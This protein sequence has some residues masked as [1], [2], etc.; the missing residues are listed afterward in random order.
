MCG[1]TLLTSLFFLIC[2]NFYAD[3]LLW[4]GP[5]FYCKLLL[6]FQ[7]DALSKS[8]PYNPL[9]AQL[10]E[11]YGALG[12]PLKIAKTVVTSGAKKVELLNR[13]L[14]SLTYFIRCSEVEKRVVVESQDSTEEQ[15]GDLSAATSCQSNSS[16]R[17]T[18][19]N[20]DPQ[21]SHSSFTRRFLSSHDV[22][23][24][25]D[26]RVDHGVEIG[27]E[28]Q[29]ENSFCPF[30]DKC[31][32]NMK[33]TSSP[34][35]S[36][37]IKGDCYSVHNV[38]DS[39]ERDFS[40]AQKSVPL[41]QSSV[42]YVRKDGHLL[43]PPGGGMRRTPSFMKRLDNTISAIELEN[44]DPKSCVGTG[45]LYPSLA[46]L[47]IDDETEDS[48]FPLHPDNK[49][50]VADLERVELNN[51][52][53]DFSFRHE[54]ISLKVSRLC[55]VPTSA[56]L[57]HLQNEDNGK[58]SKVEEVLL[59]KRVESERQRSSVKTSPIFKAKP[60]EVLENS[61]N[62]LS[63]SCTVSCEKIS[64]KSVSE[65]EDRS[66][67]GDVIFVIGDNEQLIDIKQSHKCESEHIEKAV[68]NDKKT[69]D[70]D[71]CD[72]YP[73]VLS[74]SSLH[75]PPLFCEHEFDSAKKFQSDTNVGSGKHDFLE[76][77]INV[78]GREKRTKQCTTC[79]TS[80]SGYRVITVRPSVI[81]LEREHGGL[82]TDLSVE[83]YVRTSRPVSRSL[84]LLSPLSGEKVGK[85]TSPLCRR[86]SDCVCDI[87]RYLKA[88]H[89]VRFHFERCEGVLMNYIEGRDQ[90]KSLHQTD[91]KTD[92]VAE[93]RGNFCLHESSVVCENYSC[94]D[95]DTFNIGCRTVMDKSVVDKISDNLDMCVMGG[96]KY[97]CCK[98]GYV[99]EGNAIFDDYSSLSEDDVL[100]D[101]TSNR[102]TEE[103]GIT[104]AEQQQY[105][106]LLEL[107][108]PRLVQIL[109]QV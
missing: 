38:C 92:K 12:Y 103:D 47:Q 80:K 97:P 98:N 74:T 11:L 17:T 36:K 50:S 40:S 109:Y 42:G 35:P 106:S 10:G 22:M 62:L 24:V 13:I 105:E 28:L 18:L 3:G 26:N 102:K 104:S 54:D 75:A 21:P 32:N 68:S 63:G 31:S 73:S 27:R 107:P 37:V 4:K 43:V 90:K 1:F 44:S 41:D 65:D 95:T 23:T 19:L 51:V 96:Q 84:S 89:S 34:L 87:S 60:S 57:Y 61:E 2:C 14:S 25:F 86:H 16:S 15:F 66:G 78:P 9:W 108:M 45:R 100:C 82:K 55:R 70:H 93:A 91:K 39:K 6:L 30:P 83:N 88:Y 69:L 77:N 56:I 67:K 81:E 64:V 99:S 72:D 52:K 20:E 94:L 7:L 59:P 49:P 5:S 101:S 58:D 33:M 76:E 71:A 53:S 85:K 46:D 48:K 8:H 29:A 79:S